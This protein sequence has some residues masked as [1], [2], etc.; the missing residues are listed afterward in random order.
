MTGYMGGDVRITL[1]M[2]TV[3]IAPGLLGK[4]QALAPGV[5]M[6]TF[7]DRILHVRA[8]GIVVTAIGHNVWALG[9]VISPLLGAWIGTA[10]LPEKKTAVRGTP[11]IS[12]ASLFKHRELEWEWR[13]ANEDFLRRNYLDQWVVLD[14]EEIVAF[15]R[16][17][18]EVVAQAKRKGVLIPY[19]FRVARTAEGISWIGL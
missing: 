8:T 5:I 3:T 7:A 10:R 13:R 18:L 1:G 2:P 12:Q 17:P 11:V 4:K 15:G 9:T 16:D 14:G 19:V 6:P